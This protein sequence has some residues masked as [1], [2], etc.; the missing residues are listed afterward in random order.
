[1]EHLREAVV[2]A[3]L[4]QDAEI[5]AVRHFPDLGPFQGLASQLRP[6]RACLTVC[7]KHLAAAPAMHEELALLTIDYRPE[8]NAGIAALAV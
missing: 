2:E 3:A 6:D 1:M 4:A 7:D 8:A 5:M